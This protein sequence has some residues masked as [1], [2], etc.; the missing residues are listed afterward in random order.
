MFRDISEIS[1]LQEGLV[2]LLDEKDVPLAAVGD[3]TLL[4]EW[5]GAD[6]KETEE[7]GSDYIVNSV[8]SRLTGNETGPPTGCPTRP[9]GGNNP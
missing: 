8:D 3:I 4:E 1:G 9:S 6:G 5:T 2:C 7:S